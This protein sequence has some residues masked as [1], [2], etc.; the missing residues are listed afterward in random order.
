MFLQVLWA[1]LANQS[2]MRKGSL[3]SLVY[4]WS[5]Q[6]IGDLGL[7][8]ET[9][10]GG[11]LVGVLSCCHVWLFA[12]PW[13]VAHQALLS[14]GFSRQE[15]WSG[16]PFSFSRGSFWP[17]DQTCVSWIAGWFFTC[18][19]I[20][21]VICG[22]RSEWSCRNPTGV[23]VLLDDV[24]TTPQPV[25]THWDWRQNPLTTNSH[26]T[27]LYSQFQISSISMYICLKNESK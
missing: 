2:N 25:H 10:E 19:A 21:E 8:C 6:S 17:R 3:E 16:L 4:S 5:V 1:T 27:N 9:G 18:W 13:T 12:T 20:G 15:Y 14:M 24:G 23:W 11:S 22:I 26:N 7:A